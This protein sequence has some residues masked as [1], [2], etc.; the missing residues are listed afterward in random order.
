MIFWATFWAIFQSYWI[1]TQDIAKKL[2][3][4]FYQKSNGR[5]PD[6]I[7]YYRDGVS[8]GQFE[9]ILNLEMTAIQRAC[10][11]LD[12]DYEPGTGRV[13]MIF[14]RKYSV[15]HNIYDSL[16]NFYFCKISV[17]LTDGWVKQI[18]IHIDV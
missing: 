12:K 6:K 5:K 3:E 17:T 16:F 1:A 4:N 15:Q 8:E 7:I 9:D 10:K 18:T 2:L 11:Q 14:I 13:E